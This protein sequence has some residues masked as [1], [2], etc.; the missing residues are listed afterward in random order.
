MDRILHCFNDLD[1]ARQWIT[2][3]SILNNSVVGL[4][5]LITDVDE[6]RHMCAILDTEE[7]KYR[8]A[9]LYLKHVV[10]HDEPLSDSI[11]EFIEAR[12]RARRP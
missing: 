12:V 11:K 1:K 8:Y 2:D 9:G 6:T 7:E 5:T 4:M 3:F 10:W